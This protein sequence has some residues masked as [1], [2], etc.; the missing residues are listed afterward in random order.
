MDPH[1]GCIRTEEK[2]AMLSD[3]GVLFLRHGLERAEEQP[4][5][6]LHC[7]QS[8]RVGSVSGEKNGT[9]LRG[10]AVAQVGMPIGGDFLMRHRRSRFHSEFEP[11]TMQLEML[12]S[13]LVALLLVSSISC[14]PPHFLSLIKRMKYCQ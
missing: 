11:C 4:P 3:A 14:P 12:T 5:L 7:S 6:L 9:R 13:V 10:S 2:Q 8:G 1:G